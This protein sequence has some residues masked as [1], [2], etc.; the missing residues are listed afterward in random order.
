MVV[1]KACT[2]LWLR[3]NIHLFFLAVNLN[4]RGMCL[5]GLCRVH[6]ILLPKTGKEEI[7][8]D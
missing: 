4:H 7:S 1:G 5:W 8:F 6:L 3:C 2:H